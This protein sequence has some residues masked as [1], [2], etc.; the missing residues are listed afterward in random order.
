MTHLCGEVRHVLRLHVGRSEDRR[1]PTRPIRENRRRQ[2]LPA[3]LGVRNAA[4]ADKL[5]VIACDDILPRKN[6]VVPGQTKRSAR[7]CHADTDGCCTDR[8]NRVGSP[9]K[10]PTKRMYLLREEIRTRGEFVLRGLSLP[11]ELQQR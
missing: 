6:I 8:S 2:E 4:P 1:R 11:V 3:R 9:P 10:Q 7:S 5:L